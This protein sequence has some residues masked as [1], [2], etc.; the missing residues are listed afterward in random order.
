MN[1]YTGGREKKISDIPDRK[2][3]LPQRRSD[4]LVI[5]QAS[6]SLVSRDLRVKRDPETGAI[7]RIIDPAWK[8]KD[9]PLNDPLEDIPH[10]END[11]RESTETES[12]D[13][14]VKA[15]VQQASVETGKKQ[16]HPSRREEEWLEALEEKYGEDYELMAKDRKLNPYQ[17]SVGNIRRRMK[18]WKAL[19]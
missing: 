10:N 4:P 19:R 11:T 7:V 2:N 16:R 14:I 8:T 9:N 15:L 1:A 18:T 17:Q 6:V 5:V 3:L 12:A 13:G